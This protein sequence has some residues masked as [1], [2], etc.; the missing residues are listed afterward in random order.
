MHLKIYHSYNH[1]TLFFFSTH[2]SAGE[3]I[4]SPPHICFGDNANTTLLK[5]FS[6][7]YV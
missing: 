4:S 6:F 1:L 5:T 2:N 3:M 7:Y